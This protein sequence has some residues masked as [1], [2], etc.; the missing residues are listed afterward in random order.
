MCTI[1]RLHG[2]K[3]SEFDA[4]LGLKTLEDDIGHFNDNPNFTA[5]VPNLE[6]INPDDCF[7]SVPYGIFLQIISTKV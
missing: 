2:E 6:G 3:A 1:G 4:I 5:L 7:S